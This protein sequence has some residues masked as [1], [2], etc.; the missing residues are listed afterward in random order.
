MPIISRAEP[1]LVNPPKPAIANGKIA[2]HIKALASPN[3]A[4]KVIAT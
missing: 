1:I 4:M 3:K 2:G